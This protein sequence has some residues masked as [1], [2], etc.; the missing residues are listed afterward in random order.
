MVEFLDANF[1]EKIQIH[2]IKLGNKI[3]V[4]LCGKNIFMENQCEFIKFKIINL[5]FLINYRLIT[6]NHFNIRPCIFM[7]I[8]NN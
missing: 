2:F 5:L 6:V 1:S 8:R 4:Q 7:L 3:I